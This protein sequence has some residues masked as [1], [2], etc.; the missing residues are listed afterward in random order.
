MIGEAI[1]EFIVQVVLEV[2]V[3]F[4]FRYPGALVIQA[5]TGYRKPFT[6]WLNMR[7]DLSAWVGVCTI[8]AII[9]F[10]AAV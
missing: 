8:V 2:F 1:I 5:V 10:A 3:A 7:P 9:A 4:L 6:Y